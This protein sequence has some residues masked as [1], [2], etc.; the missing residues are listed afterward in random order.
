VF[1]S[2]FHKNV[3]VFSADSNNDGTANG[4]D[5]EDEPME[6]DAEQFEDADD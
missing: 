2:N 6:M 3:L 5:V 1:C 4:N